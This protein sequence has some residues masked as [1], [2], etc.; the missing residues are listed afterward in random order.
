MRVAFGLLFVI[1]AIFSFSFAAV[2]M[3]SIL[4]DKNTDKK[5]P[6]EFSTFTSAVCN[7]DGNFVNCKDEMFVQ[8]NGKVSKA[9]EIKDCN[10]FS[11]DSNK[12]TG[13]AVFEKEWNDP[14]NEVN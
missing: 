14:R 3:N 9:D 5:S 13:L 4:D 8:C 2:K 10:G 7:N 12:I 11:L 6:V 1:I